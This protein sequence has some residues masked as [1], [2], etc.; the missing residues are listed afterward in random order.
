VSV[1][2]LLPVGHALARLDTRTAADWLGAVHLDALEEVGVDAV[3]A[4][5]RGRELVSWAGFGGVARGELVAAGKKVTGIAQERRRA[6]VVLVAGTLVTPPDWALLCR[7][8]GSPKDAGLLAGSTI[9][10][11]EVAATPRPA[12]AFAAALARRLRADQHAFS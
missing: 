9:S 11:A 2:V 12:G 3:R 10:C 8:M 1:A 7:A 4:E 6:G 5:E